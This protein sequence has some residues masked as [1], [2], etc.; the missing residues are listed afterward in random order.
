MPLALMWC[1]PNS[2]T[3]THPQRIECSQTSLIYIQA[4]LSLRKQMWNERY[5][6][7]KPNRIWECATRGIFLQW[8]E[9]GSLSKKKCPSGRIISVLTKILKEFPEWWGLDW[10]T[11]A[12]HEPTQWDPS[13]KQGGP[14]PWGKCHF[15]SWKPK[16]SHLNWLCLSVPRITLQCSWDTL[17]SPCATLFD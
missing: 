4:L 11:K 1:L 7:D 9:L 12:L 10:S 3:V 14:G 6:F 8:K 2:D 15:R 5:K 13:I 16:V 17:C